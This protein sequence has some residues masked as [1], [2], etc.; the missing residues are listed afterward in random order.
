M[1]SRMT[2]AA[3][4]A[5]SCITSTLPGATVKIPDFCE[6]LIYATETDGDMTVFVRIDKSGF[7]PE[8]PD[9]L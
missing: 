9:T 5:A 1:P 3:L 8:V 4:M 2:K 6:L 7:E